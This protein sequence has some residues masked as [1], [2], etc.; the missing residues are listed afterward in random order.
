MGIWEKVI[1]AFIAVAILITVSVA[2]LDI[3][4]VS[5]IESNCVKTELVDSNNRAVFDCTGIDI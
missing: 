2:T 4:T 1:L 3:K 5:F